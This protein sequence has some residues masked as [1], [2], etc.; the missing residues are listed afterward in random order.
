MNDRLRRMIHFTGAAAGF[1]F[2]AMT[3]AASADTPL[4]RSDRMSEASRNPGSYQVAQLFGESDADKAARLQME[5]SQNASINYTRQKLQDMETTVRRLTGEVEEQDHRITE[6]NNRIE[7]MQRDFDYRL[8][9]I[10]QQQLSNAG[11]G[12]EQGSFSCG[13]SAAMMGSGSTVSPTM[14]DPSTAP[15]PPPPRAMAPATIPSQ[16][17]RAAAMA[18]SAP[19]GGAAGTPA[20]APGQ[21]L[22]L[23]NAPPAN[24]TPYA[25]PAATRGKFDSAMKLLTKAQYDEARSAFRAFADTYPQDE[26]APQAVYWIGD[27]ALV[28]KD[29]PGAARAF[30]EEIKKYP[31]SVRAPDSMLKLGQSLIAMGQKQEGCTALAALPTKYPN[32]S[33]TVVD[34]ATQE[35]KACR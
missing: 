6:L 26:L 29:Y 10:A 7:R 4:V 16:P 21:P 9:T 33:K 30:A 2:I 31:D 15:P 25:S 5:Q 28:Q 18:P 14:S 11:G 27:I 35:R 23:A 22:H 24:L 17:P 34:R 12:D 20:R 3:P 8:C 13:N 19:P 32:A 1:A